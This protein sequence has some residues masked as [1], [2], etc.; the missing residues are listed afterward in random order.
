LYQHDI[1]QTALT[2]KLDDVVESCVND[3][4]VNLNTASSELLTHISG[5]S[6]NVARNIVEYREEK[7]RIRNREEIKKISGVGDFRFQQAAGFL[8]IPDGEHPLDNTAIHPESYEAAEKLCNLFGIDVEN[9]SDEQ[10]KIES[11]F[12]EISKKE[13]A[14]KI[15]VGVPTL[16]LIID[17]LQKPGRDDAVEPRPV[18]AVVGVMDLACEGRHKRDLVALALCERGAARGK[19]GVVGPA[20]GRSSATAMPSP[21]PMQI[22]ATP[23]FT[24]SASIA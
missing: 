10:K 22:A 8:R 16:E 9:L 21:P 12:S 14:E 19:A 5:L 24:S 2:K 6:K 3:V 4:G 18:E 15:G 17:N 20:H 7:G 23:R 11:A 1:N 13:V